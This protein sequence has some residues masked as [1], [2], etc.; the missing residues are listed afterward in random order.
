MVDGAPAPRIEEDTA[1]PGLAQQAM[2]VWA[3]PGAGTVRMS[4][5]V[6]KQFLCGNDA[7]ALIVRIQAG[8]VVG[9]PIWTATLDPALRSVVYNVVT[10]VQGGD[11]LGFAVK[12]AGATAVC[13][14]LVFAPT[15]T[16]TP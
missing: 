8:Q 5:E 3:A 1:F 10:T 11:S 15:V 9:N 12:R 13:D 2:R 6:R 16:Y 14:D 7:V 4:G